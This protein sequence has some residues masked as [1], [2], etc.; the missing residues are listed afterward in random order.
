MPNIFHK[1]QKP[2]WIV[3]T[4]VVIISFVILFQGGSM[5]SH[6]VLG[7]GSEKVGTIYGQTIT[8]TD[9]IRDA[10]KFQI[11]RALQMDA[12]I[13]PLA[14]TAQN[15]NEALQNYVL[16]SYVFDH[17]AAALQVF[18]T[19]A[20]VQDE[21]MEVPGFQT[22][23]RFDPDKL[24][25]FVGNDLPA[26]GFTDAVIDELVRKEVQV[27]KVTELIG[28]TVDLTPAE[29]QNRFMAENQ[30]MKIDVIR[31]NTSD[32]EK[33]IAVSDA[34][35][36]KA[37]DAKK[38][39]YQ[40]EEK[41]KVSV[42][43]FELSDA[44]KQLKGKD[45]TDALQKAGNV[46]WQFAQA[47]VDKNANFADQAKKFGA[48]LTQSAFFTAE[49]PDP[50]LSN[51][52]ALA[53]TAFKLS[54]DYPSSDVLEGPNG[55]YV[56]HLEGDEPGKQMTFQEA[57]PLV[58]AEV[59]KERAAQLMQTKA[60]D[61]RNQIEAAMKAGKSI[62]DA[63]AAVGVKVE[64]VPEFSLAS[65]SKLDLPDMQPIL[66][67][68]VALGDG[69]LSDVVSTDAGGLLVYMESR[70]PMD[71]G[72]RVLGELMMKEQFTA[73]KRAGAFEEWL[74]LRR[75]AARLQLFQRAS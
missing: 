32:L 6:G 54:S 19:D 44:E 45:R 29:L 30:R 33:S 65:A 46:A 58:V 1:Y 28:V 16:N 18:P 22:N 50:A 35:A 2:I 51:I 47:A 60:T 27:K 69:Q 10:H 11:A 20:E 62:T 68:A 8:D 52:P 67:A 3:L 41:R 42:A 9:F 64:S 17:E 12:L 71:K 66:Q 49:Q 63:A 43:S 61:V 75:E 21:L 56:L 24:K 57:K 73:Q 15:I 72:S 36:Q 23:G 34:D 31:L 38:D 55:Y 25:S 4:L 70:P 14:G 59:Q 13:G 74:R 5:I 40:T 53:T 48:P 37:Y 7:G 39:S 26:L